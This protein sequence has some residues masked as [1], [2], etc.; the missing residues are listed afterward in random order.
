M[1]ESSA[2][3]A[4]MLIDCRDE[5]LKP[6]NLVTRDAFESI[7]KFRH[8]R[9]PYTFGCLPH[10]CCGPQLIKSRMRFE[11]FSGCFCQTSFLEAFG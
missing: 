4:V 2:C 6:S 1:G 5:C 8:L 11:A 7:C 10:A 9:K 3:I